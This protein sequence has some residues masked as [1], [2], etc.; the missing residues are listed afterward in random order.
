MDPSVNTRNAGRDRA[1]LERARA[2]GYLNAICR[3]R[4]NVLRAYGFWCWTLR[5][6]LI[7]FERK[8]PR[9]KY[10][11]VHLELFTTANTLTHVGQAELA[12]LCG[13]LNLRGHAALSSFD[14]VW[15]HVPINRAEELSRAILRISTRL[16]N[17]EV[18]QRSHSLEPSHAKAGASNVI[19]WPM[20]A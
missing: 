13:G 15:E 1:R 12:S 18:R 7:W 20:T 4:Q 3:S 5:V 6:P 17:Y 14:G 11:R 16:G 10:A 9:S 19:A 8:T 2:S